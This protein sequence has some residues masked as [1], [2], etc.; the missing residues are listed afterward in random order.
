[1]LLVYFQIENPPSKFSNFI[2]HKAVINSGFF[3]I[4]DLIA[5]D[6]DKIVQIIAYC[7]MPTHIHLVLKQLKDGGI[8]TYLSNV[9]NA[10][11]RYF[12]TCY[13]RKGPLWEGEFKNVLVKNDD[14]LLHLTR[15]NHLNPVTAGLVKKP[16]DWQY[17]S[18]LEYLNSDNIRRFC[19][20]ENILEI[21]PKKYRVFVEDR[22]SYQKELSIIKKLLIES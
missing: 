15:Y 7:L 2:R 1:M 19:D 5:K 9:S 14:Q 21:D 3:Q 4:F 10:Y 22:I 13:K 20:Y 18:Y 8:S 11:A 16:E 12:N 6:E 17:S